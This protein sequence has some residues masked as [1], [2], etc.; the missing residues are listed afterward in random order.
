MDATSQ[1]SARLSECRNA[2]CGLL[3]RNGR[4]MLTVA[5]AR[6]RT[7]VS[8]RGHVLRLV[9]HVMRSTAAFGRRWWGRP[10]R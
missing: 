8:R 10:Q 9:W 4:A 1:E 3:G 7:V 5:N 6:P 2:R